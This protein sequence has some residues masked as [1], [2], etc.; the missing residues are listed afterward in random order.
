MT[1]ERLWEAFCDHN[2]DLDPYNLTYTAWQ[3]IDGKKGCDRLASLVRAGIKTATSSLVKIFELDGEEL[4]KEGDYSV[5]MDSEE[6]ALFIIKNKAVTV[7]KFRDVDESI[8]FKEG[9]GDQTLEYWR[10]VHEKYFKE[11]C[12]EY[13]IEFSEDMEVL[14]EEFELIFQ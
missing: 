2:L 12:E 4:P 6:D 9:E 5:I 14:T 11:Q 7:N 1:P 13:G 3:F 8:A 10:R